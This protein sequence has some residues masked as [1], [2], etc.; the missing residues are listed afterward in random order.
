L[1]EAH[2]RGIG[3]AGFNLD[4]ETSPQLGGHLSSC[5]DIPPAYPIELLGGARLFADGFAS[6][7]IL[8]LSLSTS[9]S[10]IVG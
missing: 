9:V 6:V 2:E 4:D 8:P 1:S 10:Y 3:D 5:C 7:G